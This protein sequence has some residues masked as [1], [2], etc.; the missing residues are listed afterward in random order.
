MKSKYR[1]LKGKTQMKKE[2]KTKKG[3]ITKLRRPK[4]ETKTKQK[5]RKE[6]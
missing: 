5:P 6:G 1:I 2:K 4:T 3:R